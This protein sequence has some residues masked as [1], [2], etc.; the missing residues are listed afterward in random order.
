MGFVRDA[1]RDK[2][3]QT[4][5]WLRA[6]FKDD[7]P[8]YRHPGKALDLYAQGSERMSP[9]IRTE[10]YN[11]L[12]AQVAYY[13]AKQ[14]CAVPERTVQRLAA[15][16]KDY[17][18][19]EI[20]DKARAVIQQHGPITKATIARDLDASKDYRIQAGIDKPSMVKQHQIEFTPLKGHGAAKTE[21]AKQLTREF[22]DLSAQAETGASKP[23]KLH[24]KDHIYSAEV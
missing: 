10:R 2:W 15:I 11:D 14:K 21:D 6:K 1:V 16:D 12:K 20:M 3:G 19:L 8:L 9:E 5:D 24:R 23:P 4:K 13:Y 7:D 18:R 17:K 22:K